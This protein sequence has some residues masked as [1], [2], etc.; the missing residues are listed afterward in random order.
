MAGEG[1]G[2]SCP[3]SPFSTGVFPTPTHFVLAPWIL[4]RAVQS[5][6]NGLSW[7]C[8][9]LQLQKNNHISFISSRKQFP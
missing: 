1:T 8:S 2:T 4:G 5:A 9:H 7:Y 6:L 3:L